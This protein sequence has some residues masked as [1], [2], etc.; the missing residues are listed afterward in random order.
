M[1]E[2]IVQYVT[3]TDVTVRYS[4]RGSMIIHLHES[5]AI[6]SVCSTSIYKS[7]DIFWKKDDI[8]EFEYTKISLAFRFFFHCLSFSIIIAIIHQVVAT[9]SFQET[10]MNIFF[11]LFYS[12]MFRMV[13]HL[14]KL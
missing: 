7:A 14:N 9:G 4:A 8:F 11:P 12:A 5:C 10:T 1:S 13:L 2:K 6:Y 3:S